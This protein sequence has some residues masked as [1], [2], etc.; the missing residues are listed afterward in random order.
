MRPLYFRQEK[1]CCYSI[2]KTIVSTECRFKYLSSN[3]L[4]ADK[5]ESGDYYLKNITVNQRPS[6]SMEDW[7]RRVLSGIAAKEIDMTWLDACILLGMPWET[8][9]AQYLG[10]EYLKEEKEKAAKLDE[11]KEEL[12]ETKAWTALAEKEAELKRLKIQFQDQKRMYTQLQR[13]HARADHL[14]DTIKEAVRNEDCLIE[15]AEKD[16]RRTTTVPTEA[17]LLLSDWHK[18]Q[19]SSNNWNVYNDVIF[20]KRI[21]NLVADTIKYCE[22]NQVDKLHVFVLGDLI[23]GLI[24]VSTRISNE[25]NVI[26]QTVQVAKVL[27][28][29]LNELSQHFD[30]YCY[31]SRG[32]HDRVTANKK[33]SLDDESFFDLLQYIVDE[34]VSKDHPTLHIMQN[35]VDPEI[36]RT[37]IAGHICYGVHGHK[38]KPQK[39][40]EKLST[41]MHE[42]PDFIFEGHFHSAAEHEV[43]GIEVIVNS[44]LCGTD[45]YAVS[46]RRNS[47]PSQKL[48]IINDLGR[49]CTYNLNVSKGE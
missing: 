42:I 31:F 2:I 30:V 45:S 26:A 11:Q 9:Q 23:N 29:V 27:K 49:I 38:D 37:E 36:I 35:E 40:A 3:V 33:E 19:T 21:Q 24:H 28:Q 7:R 8:E 20:K 4:I 32:N 43:N 15:F 46:L 10:E 34:A 44:S 17:A 13:R 22:L 16:L 6:E 39:V 14:V 48:I 12:R 25:E 47:R 1:E 41:F 5:K 18:G